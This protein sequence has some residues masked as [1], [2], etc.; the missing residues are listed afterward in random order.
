MARA[1]AAYTGVCLIPSFY[2]IKSGG[3]L[4]I[5]RRIALD[6]FV[7][8]GLFDQSQVSKMGLSKI[9]FAILG[10]DQN[11]FEVMKGVK[12]STCYFSKD[13]GIDLKFKDHYFFTIEF[14][15]TFFCDENA[16]TFIRQL[17]F[18]LSKYTRS[19]LSI[20]EIHVAQDYTNINPTDFFPK[21]FN[22]KD[23]V[24]CF[25]V[26][27]NPILK[28]KKQECFTTFYLKD[29]SVKGAKWSMCFYDKTQELHEKKSSN[30]D[31]K[32]DY[33]KKLGYFDLN[34]TRVELRINSQL[35][36]VHFDSFFKSKNMEVF[37]KKILS[38]FYKKRKIYELKKDQR[39]D[40]KHPERFSKYHLWENIFENETESVKNNTGEDLELLELLNE[41]QLKKG[42]INLFSK[43]PGEISK[44]FIEEVCVESKK[45]RKK[46]IER[47]EN[48]VRKK[49]Q[50]L[51]TF[52]KLE[53]EIENTFYKDKNN[54]LIPNKSSE[55][56]IFLEKI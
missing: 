1:V 39:F 23:Y 9:I 7:M 28:I 8:K 38:T 37:C 24:H 36:K 27:Y 10:L 5:L 50:L 41:E 21:G 55:S 18:K 17:F 22:H 15:S 46:R 13:Y 40:K 26:V 56:F 32:N 33:Y 43:F 6:K 30:S 2:P 48:T 19:Q 3:I 4:V 20:S 31:T 52:S 29:P 16:F 25:N 49:E 54:K 45:M 12:N 35:S 11:S 42:M 44:E 47:K 14:H 34:V 53:L 51:K